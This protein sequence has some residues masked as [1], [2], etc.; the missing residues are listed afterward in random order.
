M[1][2]GYP[3]A[4]PSRSPY[5]SASLESL[6]IS[7]VCSSLISDDETIVPRHRL[8]VKELLW[9]FLARRL[10]PSL[11]RRGKA[12]GALYRTILFRFAFRTILS[13]SQ[14]VRSDAEFEWR[15]VRVVLAGCEVDVCFE[16]IGGALGGVTPLGAKE[17]ES[18]PSAFR[19]ML[20]A[21]VLR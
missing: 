19:G 16:E 11:L 2:H 10:W 3:F 1:S 5:P 15:R 7:N 17:P 9:F 6:D 8:N 21:R 14:G 18:A 12:L 13:L 4:V 20:N